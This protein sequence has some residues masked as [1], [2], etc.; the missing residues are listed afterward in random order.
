[1]R[2]YAPS[3]AN[4]QKQALDEGEELKLAY[5]INTCEYCNGILP[6]L[7]EHIKNEIEDSYK[8]KVDLET[9][10]EVFRVLINQAIQSLLNSVDTK[11][12]EQYSVM[13]KMNWSNFKSVND[14][15]DCIKNVKKVLKAIAKVLEPNLNSTYYSYFMNKL[16]P[17]IP[18]SF[19]ESIYKIKK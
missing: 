2:R 5:I 16:G 3:L 7:D 18:K 15:L 12:S 10:Q 9:S 8:D 13:I 17:S 4:P 6:A 11:I 14:N 19:I 1:L